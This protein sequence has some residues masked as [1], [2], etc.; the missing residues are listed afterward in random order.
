MEHDQAV[1]KLKEKKSGTANK[2]DFNFQLHHR[3]SKFEVPAVV[4]LN[5]I[6]ELFGL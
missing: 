5:H 6:F 2:K 3:L 4:N 1:E